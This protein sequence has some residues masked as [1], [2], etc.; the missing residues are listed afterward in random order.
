[1][2]GYGELIWIGFFCTLFELLEEKHLCVVKEEI[3]ISCA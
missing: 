2:E 3:L 1:M